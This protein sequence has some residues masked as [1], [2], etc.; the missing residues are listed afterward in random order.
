MSK[1]V[2]GSKLISTGLAVF[3]M[4]FGAGNLMYPIAVGLSSGANNIYGMLG[5]TITAVLLPVVGLVAMILFDGDYD[6]FFQRLG[7]NTG[8][9]AVLLCM[10]I[11]G[12]VLVIPRIVTLSHVMIAPFLPQVSPL[13][14]A[15][16]FLSLTFLLTFRESKIVD[17]L[18]KF[19]SPALLTSL[20]I[21]IVKGLWSAGD[22][23]A[24]QSSPL[25]VFKENL[26]R[27]YGT[28]DLIG[29]IFFSAI[30]IN[31][32]KESFTVNTKKDLNELAF[33]GFKAG[34]IGTS[35]LGIIYWGMSYLGVYYGNGLESLNEG[36][37]FREISFKIL[38]SYG[39]FI[40]VIAVLMACLS[41]AIALGAVVG[42]YAQ[43][44]IFNR[45][46]GFPASLAMVLLASLPL[47]IYGLGTVL[48]LTCGPV[49]YIGYPVLI[50][51]TV[52][53]IAYKKFGFAPIKIPVLIVAI[54]ATVSYY[55]I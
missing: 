5:F 51:L 36:E 53:N 47:S 10:L 31:L 39:S 41:T 33:F 54:L 28:L 46:I 20:T 12:P 29:A 11:I 2:L 55:W 45:K 24:V 7:K 34:L 27:G 38:N 14:F 16:L 35:L 48:K 26:W 22:K 52:L 44:H 13:V 43:R 49:M 37:S 1:N 32:L 9:V 23:I 50:T 30:V 18:G 19:I 15:L 4:L 3:S 25:V 21:I 6:E 8:K 42:E 40:I 17:L